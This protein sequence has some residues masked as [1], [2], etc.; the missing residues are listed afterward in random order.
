MKRI[1]PIHQRMAELWTVSKT[2]KLTRD[3]QNEMDLCLEANANYIW[4]QIK[5]ENLSLIASMVHDHAWQHDICAQI[6]DI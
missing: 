1:L 4:K 5:L 6:E 3:E 2:R